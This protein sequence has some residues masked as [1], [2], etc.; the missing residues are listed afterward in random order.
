MTS[1]IVRWFVNLTK[2]S[3]WLMIAVGLHVIVAAVMSVMVL[4]EELQRSRPAATEIAVR[5][6]RPAPAAPIQPPEDFDRRKIP[7]LE[8]PVELV[9]LEQER[10]FVPTEEEAPEDLH[11]DLGDPTGTESGSEAFGGGTSI[12]V[13]QGGHHGTGTPSSLLSGRPG[14][15]RSPGKGRPQKG[16]TVGTEE[17]VLEGLRWLL[18]HQNEDGAWSAASL[19]TH[20]SRTPCI[21]PDPSLDASY[22]V[23]MSALAL[24]AFLGQGISVGS[25]IEI[26]DQAMG[27]RHQAGDAVKRGVRWLLDHQQEDG[28][29]SGARARRGS[30]AR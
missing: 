8:A 15:G 20:C 30:S 3:P 11:D 29:F 12:G 24:L 23:G 2:S 25:R 10:T 27:K 4:R 14:S 6:V 7:V 18:R 16:P 26:V 22:D 21:P 13:G 19:H 5:A 9:P 17:A 1:G 28:S